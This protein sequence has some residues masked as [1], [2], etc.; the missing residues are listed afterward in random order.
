MKFYSDEDE[1]AAI[2]ELADRIEHESVVFD[3]RSKHDLLAPQRFKGDQPQVGLIRRQRPEFFTEIERWKSF[4][5]CLRNHH[6]FVNIPRGNKRSSG[7][8]CGLTKTI[9][10][11]AETRGFEV[12]TTIG[13]RNFFDFLNHRRCS[14]DLPINLLS[15]VDCWVQLIQEGERYVKIL[16]IVNEGRLKSL[17]RWVSELKQLL[18]DDCNFGFVYGHA[19]QFQSNLNYPHN[20]KIDR[21]FDHWKTVTIK[22]NNGPLVF[23]L[24]RLTKLWLKMGFSLA[25][26]PE[27]DDSLALALYSDSFFQELL[28]LKP[29]IWKQFQKFNSRF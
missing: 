17:R 5:D 23:S 25:P 4:R 6:S 11:A 10:N 20:S 13:K 9:L 2:A 8:D 15:K 26:S 7:S 1:R 22:T 28:E 16:G 21:R 3:G 29:D 14:E 24:N 27:T 19:M 12:W 18:I